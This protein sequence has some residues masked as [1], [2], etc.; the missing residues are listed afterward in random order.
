MLTFPLDCFQVYIQEGFWTLHSEKDATWS[1]KTQILPTL[2]TRSQSLT[3]FLYPASKITV[4]YPC[5]RLD[6]FSRL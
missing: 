1:H 2:Y 3:H 5:V 4:L 6:F